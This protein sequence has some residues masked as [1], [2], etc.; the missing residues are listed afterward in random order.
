MFL[1]MRYVPPPI[2]PKTSAQA[3]AMPAYLI[4][5]RPLCIS[6]PD[7]LSAYSL[8]SPFP[9]VLRC[10]RSMSSAFLSSLT[11]GCVLP[12]RIAVLSSE[13]SKSSLIS[14]L[15]MFF[16]L[17]SVTPSSASVLR[18]FFIARLSRTLTAVGLMPVITAISAELLPKRYFWIMIVESGSPRAS[19]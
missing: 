18:I 12:M 4:I 2:P 7:T 15:F 5:P 13:P 17:Y 1:C 16:L 19:M 11:T 3:A 6:T 9:E 14:F 10:I 8:D